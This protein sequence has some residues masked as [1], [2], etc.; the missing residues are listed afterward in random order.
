MPARKASARFGYLLGSAAQNFA[1]NVQ[2]HALWEADKVQCSLHLAAHG[3]DV[4]Q[5]VGRCDL[6][7]GIGVV[8]HR[9]KKIHCLHQCH[10][11]CYAVYSRIIPAVVPDQKVRVSCAARQLF[12]NAAQHPGPQLCGTSAAGTEHDLA[13]FA[14]A[15]SPFSK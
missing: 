3:I 1:Q 14:H 5:G 10:I 11:I 9:R 15:R 7:E 8:H 13:F 4:A 2:I 6:A 12:Q